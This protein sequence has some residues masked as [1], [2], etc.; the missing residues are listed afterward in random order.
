MVMRASFTSDSLRSDDEL[1]RD[2]AN[3]HQD[4]LGPLYSRYA[5][6]VFQIG[7][8][9]LDRPAAEELVQE[10][11]LT[12][13]RGAGGFDPAQGAFRPWLL[14][15]THWKILN[16][17]RR[18]RRRPSEEADED[19]L[20]HVID[21]APGPEEQ[22]WQTEHESIVKSA[23]EALPPKQRQA[24]ALAFLEDMT[25]EQVARTLDV[26]LGTAKTRIRS[27]LQIMRSHLAPMAASLLTLAIGVIGFRLVQTQITLDRDQRAI[28]MVTTSELVP[29]RLT[30]AAGASVPS[31]AHA[32]YRGRPGVDIAVL[33]TELLPP[34][35]AGQTYHAW[36]HHGEVWT[37]LGSFTPDANGAAQLVAQD[38]ALTQTPD[39][40]EITLERGGGHFA[41]E[42]NVVLA[43]PSS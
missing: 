6:L 18:R 9:S 38:A 22:A 32:N 16:E 23:L 33:S 7:V 21:H 41:P 28:A 24:I 13:W 2:L 40:V 39:A 14:R 15:L 36:V 27:G 8:Q 43:W 1:M 34:A 20:E 12:I 5:S 42:G 11:F 19:P 29:L 35:P 10:V 31:G 25:H 30:P 3:G 4:A 26:P 37:S 17:L